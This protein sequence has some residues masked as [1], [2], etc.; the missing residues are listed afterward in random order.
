M[1]AIFQQLANG[2]LFKHNYICSLLSLT[3]CI[4][5]VSNDRDI[6]ACLDNLPQ[7]MTILGNIFLIN[8]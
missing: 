3:Y 8:Y 5:K 4:F 6:T 7:C 1:I 2:L